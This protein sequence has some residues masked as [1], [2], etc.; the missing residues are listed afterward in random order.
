MSAGCSEPLGCTFRFD[1]A[2]RR[3]WVAGRHFDRDLLGVGAVMRQCRI[4]ADLDAVVYSDGAEGTVWIIRNRPLHALLAEW[5]GGKDSR[6]V[7][8]E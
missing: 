8:Y 5:A 6:K 2:G 7:R 1:V 3:L 4:A